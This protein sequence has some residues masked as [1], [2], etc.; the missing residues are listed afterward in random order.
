MKTVFPTAYHFGQVK[1]LPWYG[2]QKE[3]PDYQLTVDIN[4]FAVEEL[5]RD[6][7]VRQVGVDEKKPVTTSLLLKRRTVFNRRL[8]GQ[9]RKHHRVRLPK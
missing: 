5:E 6:G 3:K 8:L 1:G 7:A 9:V 4:P 2:A